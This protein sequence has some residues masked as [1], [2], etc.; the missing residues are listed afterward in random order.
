MTTTNEIVKITQTVVKQ[1]Y[2]RFQDNIYLQHGIAMS[3]PMSSILL[4]VHIQHMEGTTIPT[5]LS[6][7]IKL[8]YR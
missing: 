2:F 4:E 5:I 1:N 7:H 3:S 8:F 6:K